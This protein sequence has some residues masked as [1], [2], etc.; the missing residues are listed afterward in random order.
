RAR[1][2][3]DELGFDNAEAKRIAKAVKECAT[4]KQT[5]EALEKRAGRN[6]E[7]AAT[8]AL[9]LQASLERR[10]TSSHYTPP[11]LAKSVVERALEPLIATMGPAP[12]SESLLN[13][14]VCDPAM[15]S[16]AFLVAACE[17][18]A[19]QLV[20]AWSREGQQQLI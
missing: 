1:W 8:G 10:R 14:V 16:G 4:A 5:P 19:A 3:G 18:L 12:K 15:G 6:P 11:E 7:R 9:V 13:L 2:L 17:Y 20:A